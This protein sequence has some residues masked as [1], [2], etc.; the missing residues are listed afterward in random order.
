MAISRAV[1]RPNRPTQIFLPP[2]PFPSVPSI[3]QSPCACACE[4]TQLSLCWQLCECVRHQQQHMC[5][6][7][8]VHTRRNWYGFCVHAR[9]SH[10]SVVSLSG[11]RRW[12]CTCTVCSA[13]LAGSVRDY[14]RFL[15]ICVVQPTNNAFSTSHSVNWS[16][17]IEVA[18]E[19][20]VFLSDGILC[21][22]HS[23]LQP[24]GRLLSDLTIPFYYSFVYNIL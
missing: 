13:R 4:A 18:R 8:C 6:T 7:I 2:P 14:E 24:I 5:N 21:K 3:M 1:A 15:P 23:A 17:H 12:R 20:L 16:N 10:I 9:I 22:T 11:H 19:S